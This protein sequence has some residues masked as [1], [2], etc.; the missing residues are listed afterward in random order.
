MLIPN[1]LSLA[2][3]LS[4]SPQPYPTQPPQPAIITSSLKSLLSLISWECNWEH[5]S[6]SLFLRL[7]HQIHMEVRKGHLIDGRMKNKKENSQGTR[8]WKETLTAEGQIEKK[9]NQKTKNAKCARENALPE[10][11]RERAR[12]PYGISKDTR[13]HRALDIQHNG[14]LEQHEGE[15]IKQSPVSG[16]SF[17]HWETKNRTG[18]ARKLG[19]EVAWSERRPGS[20]KRKTKPFR[21]HSFFFFFFF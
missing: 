6:F 11:E 13:G 2:P 8:T 19:Q 16:K 10:S 18:R 1:F 15:Y 3:I 9:S 4:L 7:F 20:W 14:E 5:A 12:D 21:S 17:L